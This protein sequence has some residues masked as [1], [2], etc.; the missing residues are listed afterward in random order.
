MT[1]V[2]CL[3]CG[4]VRS[5]GEQ[6]KKCWKCGSSEFV[7]TEDPNDSN[8]LNYQD[9]DNKM[10]GGAYV[11]WLSTSAVLFLANLLFLSGVESLGNPTLGNM[12]CILIGIITVAVFFG[13]SWS[14]LST[15]SIHRSPAEAV[16]ILLLVYIG[17][18]CLPAIPLLFRGDTTGI[19]ASFVIIGIVL[20]YSY[21]TIAPLGKSIKR[22]VEKLDLKDIEVGESFSLTLCHLNIAIFATYYLSL[23]GSPFGILLFFLL[24]IINFIV[25]Y[26]MLKHY[27]HVLNIIELSKHHDIAD[28]NPSEQG[29]REVREKAGEIK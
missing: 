11:F 9:L 28:E 4:T 1:E 26:C 16:I 14:R 5:D 7:S 27:C 20:L 24:L 12:L 3:Q 25:L 13:Q 29:N 23:M 6:Q 17:I 18:S 8:N 21:I 2:E 19:V 22:E 10:S 15:A